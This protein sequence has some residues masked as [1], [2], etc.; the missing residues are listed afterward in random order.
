MNL[1]QAIHRKN[2]LPGA[3]ATLHA[4]IMRRINNRYHENHDTCSLRRG[5]PGLEELAG[6]LPMV[7]GLPLPAL[8]FYAARILRLR[9]RYAVCLRCQA[10]MFG[11][12][13]LI[14]AEGDPV[15]A[16]PWRVLVRR[17]ESWLAERGEVRDFLHEL[18]M[19]LHLQSHPAP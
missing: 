14:L 15:A 3:S 7:R 9:A 12:V 10:K 11:L 16:L 5:G 6:I 17:N 4:E 19:T 2:P 1:N 18:Q 8:R 13:H